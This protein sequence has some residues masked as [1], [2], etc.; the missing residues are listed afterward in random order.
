MRRFAPLTALLCF[1]SLASAGEITWSELSNTSQCTFY[2]MGWQR[3]VIGGDQ[4]IDACIARCETRDTFG[5]GCTH[6]VCTQMCRHTW[7]AADVRAEDKVKSAPNYAAKPGT[8]WDTLPPTSST[9]SVSS[10]S[11]LRREDAPA[12]AIKVTNKSAYTAQV[13]LIHHHWE[14]G[15]LPSGDSS[16]LLPTQSKRWDLSEG[17]PFYRVKVLWMD[18]FTER[19]LFDQPACRAA[20]DPNCIPP[21]QLS[22]Y[23]ITGTPF[24]GG[25]S[26]GP[27]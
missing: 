18:G 3:M 15:I 2:P 12:V 6:D 23:C 5:Q 1:A 11:S 17:S 16:R 13:E 14:D 26:H 4:P 19:V 7:T 9:T 24:S 27:C 21:E 25:A 20:G 8:F 10:S 22:N